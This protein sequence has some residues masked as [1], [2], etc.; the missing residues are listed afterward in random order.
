LTDTPKIEDIL[1]KCVEL[2]GLVARTDQYRKMKKAEYDLLHNQE[3]RKMMEDLQQ[4]Q[5]DQLKKEMAGLE[6]TAEEKKRLSETEK[7][8][9]QH[10]VI[11]ASHLANA[12]FQDLMKEISKKIREGIKVC[13]EK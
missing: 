3:A 2:G 10:P 4:L 1:E 6:M 8:A 11:R 7:T 13:E 9:V 5:Q 12:D